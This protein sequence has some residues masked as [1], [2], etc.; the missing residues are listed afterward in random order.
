VVDG[1]L[2]VLS[3]AAMKSVRF[4]E[5]TFDGFDGYDADY[6]LSSREA[7]LRVVVEHFDLYHKSI[8]QTSSEPYRRAQALFQRKWGSTL[9]RPLLRVRSPKAA[10]AQRELGR[11]SD[12]LSPAVAYGHQLLERVR[13]RVWGKTPLVGAPKIPAPRSAGPPPDCILCGRKMTE[14]TAPLPLV[15]CEHCQLGKTWP[16]PVVDDSSSDIFDASYEGG[17]Q[18]L[19]QQWI[20]EAGQRLSWLETWTPEGIL[21]EVGCATG[22]FV[23][24]AAEAGYDA[25]GVEPSRWAA[26][27]AREHGADVTEGLLSDWIAEYGGFTVDAIAMF[28]VLEHLETPTEILEECASILA[29]D[30]KLF[31]EVPN[32]TCRAAQSFDASWAGWEFRFHHWHHSPTS[33]RILFERAGLRV[34]DL[35]AISGRPYSGRPEWGSIRARDKA[36]GWATPDLNYLRVVAGL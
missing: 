4:D 33:L 14:V 31:L 24:V 15:R 19:R 22:E 26:K 34:L 30:G 28:H 13:R 6:C 2:M 32:A 17:R 3:P 36:A 16:A 5:E 29:G 7:G 8:G 21:L 23:N 10:I 9:S 1:L 12:A 27:I 18:N 25:L 20:W 35:H 11:M